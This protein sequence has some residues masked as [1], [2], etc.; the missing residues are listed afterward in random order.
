MR[1]DYCKS[2]QRGKTYTSILIRHAV[3]VN[4][5]T[6]HITIANLTK[7]PKEDIEAIDWALKNKENLQNFKIMN[8]KRSAG[9]KYGAVYLVNEVLKKLGIDKAI[10]K[11]RQ[12][13]LA[14]MQIISRVVEQGSC[15]SAARIAQENAISE[16][17]GIQEKTC[18]DDLYKNLAWLEKNQ[19]TIEKKI[20]ENRY[21]SAFQDIFLYDVTSSYFE[22]KYNEL[23]DWGYNRDKKNGKMQVVAGLLCDEN[24]NPLSIKLFKGNT[25]DFK[26]VTDQINKITEEFAC[27]RVS[28]VG[29]RGMIK[30]RQIEELDAAGIHYITAITKPQIEKLLKANILQLGLF[31]KELK[32]IVHDGIRYILKRNPIRAE[33][34]KAGRESKKAKIKELLFVK[35]K[36]LRE[37]LKA[38]PET[39]ISD[40]NKKINKLKTGKWLCAGLSAENNRELSLN[41]DIE[42]LNEDSKLDGCYIIKSNLPKE[43]GYR[44]IHD[45]Y[46]DLKHV[47]Q[48]FKTLKTENLEIR[49][50]YVRLEESTRGKALV[51]MLAYMVLKYLR[52]AWKM[53]DYTVEEGIN[54]FDSLRL[55]E[56]NLDDKVKYYEV[57]GLNKTMSDLAKLVEVEFPQK[58]IYSE[59]NVYSRKKLV[60]D[61]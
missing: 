16:V 41:E 55:I 42:Y 10:G 23:A 6:K 24:G 15:L 5:K 43:L 56:V 17:L 4:G 38:S 60:R 30:S 46:K 48:G 61:R 59:G 20:F 50:W 58:L 26:T 8:V 40:M 18:E 29:D 22:G 57:P 39:A 21:K 19:N 49:P 27:R 45:R 44:T 54:I 28:F 13:E 51:A 1:V 53:I 32:E 9:K 31:D 3:R 36:Y 12:G 25:L 37:H 34:I 14:K 11:G 52:E 47:E 2:V 33:E 35:N 7:M